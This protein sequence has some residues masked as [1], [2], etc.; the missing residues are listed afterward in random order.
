MG[1]SRGWKRTRFSWTNITKKKPNAGSSCYGRSNDIS[2]KINAAEQLM[3]RTTHILHG[4]C[5]AD[6][7]LSRQ[8]QREEF[9]SKRASA[10]PESFFS[11]R[12]RWT[13]KRTDA[14]GPRGRWGELEYHHEVSEKIRTAAGQG[15]GHRNDGQR[16]DP[17]EK[18]DLIGPLYNFT[19]E[20]HIS[21]TG[22]ASHTHDSTGYPCETNPNPKR[23]LRDRNHFSPRATGGW[24][25][26]N[27]PMQHGY[28]GVDAG[29]EE[30]MVG[31]VPE[32]IGRHGQQQA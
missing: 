6:P 1:I 3:P 25:W 21:H 15:R 4:T 7:S 24:G 9:Q 32:M 22:H 30:E 27:G 13:G 10:G 2:H 29:G 8:P 31:F 12:T 5:I 16:N 20:Q 11:K 26:G 28:R 18:H 17:A 23:R 14:W 19:Q